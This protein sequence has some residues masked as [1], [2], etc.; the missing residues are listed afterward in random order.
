MK[1]EYSKEDID[2][3]VADLVNLAKDIVD[4]NMRKMMND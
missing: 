4:Y 1:F 2:C 3:I